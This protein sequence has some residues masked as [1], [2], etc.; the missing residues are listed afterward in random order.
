MN[1]TIALIALSLG[2]SACKGEVSLNTDPA[3]AATQTTPTTPA[4]TPTT[5]I[6]T[7]DPGVPNA[8][9]KLVLNADDA[10]Y[11]LRSISQMLVSRPL[12][13]SENDQLQ[14]E[15]GDA[16]RP[17]IEAWTSEPGF[18]DAAK[19][20]M[21]QKLKASGD[22]D[23][24]DFEAP[25]RLVAHLVANNRP[26]SE[27]ITSDY[28]IDATGAQADCDSGAPYRAGVL[29]TRAFLAGN[30]SRFNLGRASRLMKVFACRA[31]PMEDTLQ[32]YLPKETLIPM[33]RASNAEEQ[34]VE[35]AKG[36]FGNGDECYSC[37]GQFGAHAQFFVKFDQTGMWRSDATGVQ[38]PNGELG[39][40]VDGL[41]TSHME[42]MSAKAFEGSK[43][44]GKDAANLREAAQTLAESRAFVPCAV[45]NVIEYTFGMTD[46]EGEEIDRELLSTVAARA[47]MSQT[48]DPT[49]AT[50]IVETFT[51]PR[52]VDVVISARGGL[53]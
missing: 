39:R 34:T 18:V 17:I 3:P 49:L 43:M 47:T 50:I 46:S 42:D 8:A 40:S 20:M 38:D 36:A 12:T 22:R 51:D 52:V 48:V 32:P 35:E 23:G 13:A 1:H 19:Y 16:V 27:V 7:A 26:W 28:C 31:Y 14:R 24:I 6:N 10:T 9:P 44:F 33:F 5:P 25:G 21:Q 2:L 41:M 30:A 29:T 4:A 45:R 11:Y 15:G 37:H 53:Q